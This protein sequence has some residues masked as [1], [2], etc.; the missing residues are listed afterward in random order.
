MRR[1]RPRGSTHQIKIHA[2]DLDINRADKGDVVINEDLDQPPSVCTSHDRMAPSSANGDDQQSS[3]I[4]DG[5]PAIGG[6]ADIRS[7]VAIGRASLEEIDECGG[8]RNKHQRTWG[9]GFK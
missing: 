9:G 8:L 4:G 7:V 2:D 5:Q 3:P 1:D 6:S